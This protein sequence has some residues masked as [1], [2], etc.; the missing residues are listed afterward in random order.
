MSIYKIIYCYSAKIFIISYTILLSYMMIK[1][2][3]EY[4]PNEVAIDNEITYSWS[5]FQKGR[6]LVGLNFKIFSLSPIHQSD[7]HLL[8]LTCSHPPAS[9]Y[10]IY[11]GFLFQRISLV[12]QRALIPANLQTCMLGTLPHVNGRSITCSERHW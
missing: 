12:S 10:F 2:I 4:D 6:N 11:Q 5:I 3:R 1:D 7:R 8:K 9:H